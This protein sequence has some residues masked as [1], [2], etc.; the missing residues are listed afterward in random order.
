M[1]T[2]APII[3]ALPMPSFAGVFD[4]P[5]ELGPPASW[6]VYG[7]TGTGKTEAIG[8]LV[9]AGFFSKVLIINLDK[10]TE[11]LALDPAIKAATK[12]G[13]INIITVDQ[14]DPTAMAKIE[15]IILEVAGMWRAPDGSILP[16]PNLPNYGYDLVAIDTVN[17]MGEVAIKWLK[18]NTWNDKNTALDGLKAYGK[19]S[20]W[21]DEM[22]R[23]IHNSPRFVG[24]FVM[25]EK[26][27]EEKTGASKVK[28]KMEGSFKDS[29]PSI[30]SLVAHLD[31][32]K[33]PAS[34]QTVLVATVGESDTYSSKNRYQLGSKIYG[35]D[36]AETYKVIYTK[37]GLP[38]PTPAQAPVAAVQP[39]PQYSAPMA[40]P[41]VLAPPAPPMAM[42][43]PITPP[44]AYPVAPIPVAA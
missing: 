15:S 9:K 1:N 25:H 26:T 36:L 23:V 5:E 14:F 3:P 40:A 24:G 42:Q 22:I 41:A 20:V 30:P 27:Y 8:R 12:D 17:L 29:L 43:A 16:N 18:A 21:M 31:W 19:F 4:D 37:L 44:T 28:P 35:F 7:D 38:L 33:D 39:A 13:R 11:V 34:G 2:T 6:C 32:E 10:S